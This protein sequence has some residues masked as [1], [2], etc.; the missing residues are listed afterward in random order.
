MRIY[1]ELRY[2][3]FL[4]DYIVYDLYFVE[5][6]VFYDKNYELRSDKDLWYFSD[7]NQWYFSNNV[8]LGI[9]I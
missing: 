3:I 7:R 2:F 4:Y 5:L 6:V 1:I 8:V 9:D